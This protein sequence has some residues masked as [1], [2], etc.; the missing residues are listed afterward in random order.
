MD[1]TWNWPG[2]NPT[3]KIT[4]RPEDHQ[5]RQ[6]ITQHSLV[7]IFEFCNSIF[8]LY[9]ARSYLLIFLVLEYFRF[10]YQTGIKPKN[11]KESKTKQTTSL[12][13]KYSFRVVE[14]LAF[15]C[16]SFL[17]WK[18]LLF[19]IIIFQKESIFEIKKQSTSFWRYWNKI[20]NNFFFFTWNKIP[21]AIICHKNVWF[22]QIGIFKIK[23]E[24]SFLQITFSSTHLQDALQW[25]DPYVIVYTHLEQN[26]SWADKQMASYDLWTSKFKK[27]PPKLR[28][29]KGYFI[30]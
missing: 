14:M 16:W 7:T 13:Y 29:P 3:N 5:V 10:L 15:R 20:L 24:R 2:I 9:R 22:W 18:T 30:L 6:F 11:L 27:K 21:K 25:A 8:L 4:E 12:P 23:K 1:F 17:F 26:Q 19:T 28:P